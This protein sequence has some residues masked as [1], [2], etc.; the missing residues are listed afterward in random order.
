MNPARIDGATIALAAPCD[1][2]E[3]EHGRCSTL[4]VRRDISADGLAFLR[5]AWEVNAE[6]ALSI[7]GGA[8]LQLGIAGSSH[9]V[10][11]LGIGP[12]PEDFTPPLI[13][14]Q[15]I[16]DGVRAVKVQV[17]FPNRQRVF[18]A[19]SIGEDGLGAA[20]KMAV[21]EIAGFARSN[22]GFEL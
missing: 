19:V 9:P 4:W 18:A 22:Y 21:D 20:L 1:W 15:V 14:E 11:N 6:E 5:S 17:L 3:D 10:V 8:K 12:L 2:Q 13:A 16:C 7:L